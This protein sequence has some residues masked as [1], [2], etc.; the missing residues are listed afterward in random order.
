MIKKNINIKYTNSILEIVKKTIGK[1]VNYYQKNQGKTDFYIT[2]TIKGDSDLINKYTICICYINGVQKDK[3]LL[4]LDLGNRKIY[5]K[6]NG[7][8]EKIKRS[9]LQREIKL[10]ICN[11]ILK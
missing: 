5:I 7:I 4:I 2:V 8:D 10:F 1:E 6:T 3:L 11:C 9:N